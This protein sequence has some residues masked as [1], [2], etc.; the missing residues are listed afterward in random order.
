[1]PKYKDYTMKKAIVPFLLSLILASAGLTCSFAQTESEPEVRAE[2]DKSSQETTALKKAKKSRKKAI[3]KT[4]AAEPEAAPAV[5]NSAP[6]ASRKRTSREPAVSGSRPAN[7]P[8]AKAIEPKKVNSL[9]F[10]TMEKLETLGALYE[11]LRLQVSGDTLEKISGLNRVS[12]KVSADYFRIEEPAADRKEVQTYR[13]L[14]NSTLKSV[15]A[16]KDMKDRVQPEESAAAIGL[17]REL[18]AAIDEELAGSKLAVADAESSG[19]AEEA[20]GTKAVVPDDKE[21]AAVAALLELKKA[22]EAYKAGEVKYPKR[23]GK[24]VPKYI[25]EIPEISVADHPATSEVLEINSSDYDEA[26][27]QAIT[28]TGKWLYFTDKNSKYY[29]LVLIDC[30]HK[31]ARGVE[32]YKAGE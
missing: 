26:L 30:S 17:C 14:L 1:M 23:L 28:D 18:N 24:L 25:K 21:T 3:K 4:P 32:L 19:Q 11:N 31:D 6:K 15:K 7:G 27:V 9:L 2:G 13:G 8:A 12:N 29:G 16:L 5:Y 10:G 20:P 22:V